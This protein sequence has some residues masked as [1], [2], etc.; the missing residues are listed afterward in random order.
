VPPSRAVTRLSAFPHRPC[1]L[2]ILERWYRVLYTCTDDAWRS[3]SGYGVG[4]GVGRKIYR[5]WIAE[6]WNTVKPRTNPLGRKSPPFPNLSVGRIYCS[7]SHHSLGSLVLLDGP[8]FS[9]RHQG[10]CRRGGDTAINTCYTSP[11]QADTSDRRGAHI[12]LLTATSRDQSRPA[13]TSR[14]QS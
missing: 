9:H 11:Q 2:E 3:A 13:V 1:P 14:D 10:R 5:G 7:V 8:H 6:G 4:M 12:R